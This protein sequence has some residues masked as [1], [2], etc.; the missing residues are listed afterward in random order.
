MHGFSF[1]NLNKFEGFEN[2]ESFQ[3]AYDQKIDKEQE[4][5]L[6]EIAKQ[7]N[8]KIDEQ[9]KNG[10]IQNLKLKELFENTIK[11]LVNIVTDLYNGER[12]ENIFFKENRLFYLGL[13]VIFVSFCL[14]F[15]DITS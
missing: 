12:L 6:L 5:Q 13:L 7:S 14:Y 2:P 8:Q 11:S 1:L 4:E 15:I 3:T 9:L 10:L